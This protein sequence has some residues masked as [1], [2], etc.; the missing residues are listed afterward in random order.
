MRFHNIKNRK[1]ARYLKIEQRFQSSIGKFFKRGKLAS[2]QASKISNDI[3]VYPS[4]FYDHYKHLDDAFNKFERQMGPDLKALKKESTNLSLEN[5]YRK[6]LFFIFKNQKYYDAILTRKDATPFLQI[7]EIFRPVLCRQ[8]SNYSENLNEQIF[9]IFAWEF[10]GVIC[11]WGTKGKFSQ[12]E[13]DYYAIK[14]AK[15]T[16]TACARLA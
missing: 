13:I 1:D 2:L 15:L 16:K 4:T 3:N 12:D 14:L 11:H 5:T 6:I 7:V 10:C 8:W 9:Q